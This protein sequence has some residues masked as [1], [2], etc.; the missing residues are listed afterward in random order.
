M[1]A[2]H[3]VEYQNPT[4]IH[5][6]SDVA[7]LVGRLAAKADKA[8]SDSADL[9]VTGAISPNAVGSY[10]QNGTYNG[11]PAYER[12][13]GGWWI[14]YDGINPWSWKICEGTLLVSA[15]PRWAG[16][17]SSLSS[18]AVPDEGLYTTV[19][20]ATGTPTLTLGRKAQDHLASY[21]AGGNLALT[22]RKSDV[23]IK[24]DGV[25]TLAGK[26]Q[27]GNGTAATGDS[28]HA[29]GLNSRCGY[30]ADPCAI[31]GTMVTISGNATTRFTI[32]D[33]VLFTNLSGASG[34]TAPQQRTITSSPMYVMATSFSINAALNPA[35]TSGKV[36]SFNKGRYGHAEG[37]S[38]TVASDS[39][40]AEG[41]NNTVSGA[42]A[43]A[44][45]NYTTSSAQY[46][47]AEGYYATASAQGAHAGGY[48]SAA[49]KQYQRA[50]SSGRFSVSGDSQYTEIVLRRATAD[51]VPTELT[52]D[53]A[54]P[55]GTVENSS[56]RFLCVTGKTYAC[57]VMI[58]A[59][60]S[61]GAS[62]FFL[63]QVLVKNVTNTVS[64]EGTVQTVGGDINPAGWPMPTI[65]ADNTNKSLA[66]TVTG[67][68]AT[69]IR[70]SATIQAQ[71]I[72]Y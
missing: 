44:E 56:N 68:A 2:S 64:L 33:T 60:K 51:D 65:A 55:S 67:V 50:L 11:S 45:G 6:E 69:N 3:A 13:G 20:T 5:A 36:V 32:G 61:D 72:A 26:V 12:T 70:W 30:A 14:R 7:N 4:H 58:A 47:H 31:S 41:S 16:P 52:I 28:S 25:Y 57:L 63:R 10:N 66:I 18:S 21:D 54:A 35:H 49:N 9:F 22:V 71:E 38:N 59:R 24:T 48:Y 62:A 46:A 34:S 1:D 19:S 37:N 15:L 8:T 39:G 17:S 53:G 29:E 40:H 23:A 42:S 27:E 43:H